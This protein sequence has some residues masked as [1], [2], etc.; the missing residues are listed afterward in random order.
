MRT[1][2]RGTGM[3]KINIRK[4]LEVFRW[5]FKMQIVWRFDVAMT[6][7]ATVGR[8]L[9]AWILWRAIFE[10]NGNV[11]G[12][13]FDA[14][15][16][17]YIIS[18]ILNSLDFSMQISG[19]ISDLIRDGGFSKHMVTPMDPFGF[20]SFMAAG[21]SAFHFGFSCAAAFFC[22]VFFGIKIIFSTNIIGIAAALVMIPLGLFFMMCFQYLLGI[23][24]F[25]FL[26]IRSFTFIANHLIHFLT[27]ALVP[28]ALLPDAVR[29]I[30]RIF[31]FYYVTYLPSMLLIG[32]NVDEAMN[33]IL[34]L[35][36]WILA[37]MLLNRFSY[38][39]LRTRYEGVG[40]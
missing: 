2:A 33:G 26:S 1:K 29:G 18:S 36:C 11:K 5:S 22:A 9:A 35:S 15:L 40:I 25:R 16:S 4:Y 14:M 3:R 6:M 21:E 32:R 13:S 23:L 34:I 19:E 10:G 31:P 17:Y 8:I 27:G 37:F 20:F 30:M 38:N 39:S 7:L 28:L 12:F 24:T